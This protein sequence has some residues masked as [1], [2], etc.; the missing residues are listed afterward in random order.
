MLR[1][2][3]TRG[4]PRTD[5]PHQKSRVK[6]SKEPYQNT[7]EFRPHDANVPK[8]NLTQKVSVLTIMF[9]A[10]EVLCQ[11]SA[12]EKYLNVKLS[13]IGK[14]IRKFN[15]TDGENCENCEQVKHVDIPCP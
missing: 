5:S 12:E 14:H 8:Q 11:S 9:L 4:N 1:K 10:V 15:Q 6:R 2:P 13:Q 7:R 3:Q